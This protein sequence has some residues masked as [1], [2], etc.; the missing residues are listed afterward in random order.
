MFLILE[1]SLCKNFLHGMYE[2]D[3][4]IVELNNLHEK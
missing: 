1:W 3:D 2:H 4:Q